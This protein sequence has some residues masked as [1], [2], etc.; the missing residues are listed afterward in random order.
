MT[1]RLTLICAAPTSANRTFAF[2][3]DEPAEPKA[4]AKLPALAA[5]LP[6]ADRVFTS[7]GLAAM[8][9]A[10]ALGLS[11]T[12]EL[13]LRDCDYGRWTGRTLDALQAEEPASVLEWLQ[14][15]AATPHGGESVEAVI[16]RTRDWLTALGDG[17]ILAITHA[18]VIRAAIVYALGAPASSFWR[19]DITPLSAASLSGTHGRWNFAAL[20]KF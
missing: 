18:S 14:D 3:A 17:Q 6:H 8:Q 11:S 10:K 16:A 19:I 15:P 9:T 5:R 1:T 4:L 13:F 20:E 12:V 2:P 7:P